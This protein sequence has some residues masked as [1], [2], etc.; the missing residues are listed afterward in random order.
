MPQRSWRAGSF[1]FHFKDINKASPKG[2]DVPWGT[3]VCNVKGMLDEAY[4]QKFRGLVYVEYDRDWE[5]S[6]PEIA[7]SVK[8][9]DKVA[10]ELVNGRTG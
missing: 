5:N 1:E 6:L 3:G 4:R 9:F 10:A 7:Q 8:Y 2:Y